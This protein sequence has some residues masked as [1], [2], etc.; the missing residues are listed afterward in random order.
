MVVD[1]LS[2]RVTCTR[3]RPHIF[4]VL[5]QI[6]SAFLYFITE[7]AFN[8]GMNPHVYVTYRHIVGGIA[9]LPFAY[10]FERC[11]SVCKQPPH[12]P[13]HQKIRPRMTLIMFIEIFLYSLL[14]VGLTINM[15]FA[16]LNYTSPT[17]LSATVNTVPTL[18][19]V[20]AV[21]FR[22]ETLNLRKPRG[23]AKATGTFI[24][25]AGAMAIALYRGPA[26]K[27]LWEPP[28]HLTKSDF[29]KNWIKGPILSIASCISW[30]IWFTM[31]GFTLERYP[32][33][34]S[35]ATWANFMGAAQSAAFTS[36]AVQHEPVAWVRKS[37]IDI[38]TILFGG[39]VSSA[40]NFMMIVWSSKEKGPVFV[41]MFCPLQ[42]LLV[43]IFAYFFVGEKLYMGSIIG[44]VTIIIGLYLLLWGKAKDQEVSI[45]SE[46]QPSLSTKQNEPKIQIVTVLERESPNH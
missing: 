30:S 20:L 16:S 24:S 7:A 5:V 25:L 44:G 32:A 22:L 2:M 46:K 41:T 34:L 14:G 40:L 6:A 26:I 33:P 10:F 11:I 42:T 43:V 18:T 38:A 19:F 15:Y 35:L 23:L 27:S 17:F 9:V 8:R 45:T 13:T 28:I 21:V 39:V 31:Q 29:H 3:L 37:F 12:P 4:M 1:A 36:L